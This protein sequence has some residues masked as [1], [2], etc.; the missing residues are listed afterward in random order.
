MTRIFINARGVSRVITA[1]PI[2]WWVI[3]T[4]IACADFLENKNLWLN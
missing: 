4:R 2:A 1:Q 3:D